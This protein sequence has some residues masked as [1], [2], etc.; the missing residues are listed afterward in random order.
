MGVPLGDVA[1]RM[2]HSV[3]T[4]VST[5]TGALEGG[6]PLANERIEAALGG[7]LRSGV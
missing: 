6:E 7:A 2:G 5:Y 3:E 1:K 4:L